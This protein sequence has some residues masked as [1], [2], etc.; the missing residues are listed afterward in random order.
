MR[1]YGAKYVDEYI[2]ATVGKDVL[3]VGEYWTDMN[4]NGSDLDTNQ[5]A[6]RQVWCAMDLSVQVCM[7]G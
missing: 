6:A 3:C 2:S 4:W 7:I 1:G 5:D